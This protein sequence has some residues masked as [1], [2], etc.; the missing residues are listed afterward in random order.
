MN[1]AERRRNAHLEG[2]PVRPNYTLPPLDEALLV[3]DGISNLDDVASNVVVQHFDGLPNRDAPREQLDHVPRFQNDIGVVGLPRRAHGHRAMNKI[4]R[5]RHMLKKKMRGEKSTKQTKKRV[6][7]RTDVGIQSFRDCAPH[8]P[9]IF[10]AVLG[11]KRREGGFL[12]ER[13]ARVVRVGEP[14]DL[15]LRRGNE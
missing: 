11:E 15:P 5:A 4:E 2:T 3:T 8:L 13:A 10:L 14:V 6:E 12:Q 9:K 1:D 7:S